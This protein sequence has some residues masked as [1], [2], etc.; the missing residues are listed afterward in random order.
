M[1][2]VYNLQL[3]T[4]NLS[5]A[6]Y[7]QVCQTNVNL[8]QD[9]N[10]NFNSEEE[11]ICPQQFGKGYER[12]IQ[13]CKINL[14]I[15]NQEFYQDISIKYPA[16]KSEDE[17]EFG[18]HLSGSWAGKNTGESFLEW[19]VAGEDMRE[20]IIEITAEKPL[21]KVDIHLSPDLL[22]SL[23]TNNNYLPLELQELLS[24]TRQEHY[25]EIAS[26]T[27]E[28]WLPLQQILHC[29]FDGC[30]KK[31]YLEGKCL[32][33]I[34]LK[35][36]QLAR[37]ELSTNLLRKLKAEDIERIYWARDIL[38]QDLNH[39]PSL[40]QLARKIG[41]NDR[42]L[43]QGF[44]QVFNTTVFGYLHNYRMMQ[45]KQLLEA[46]RLN[47]NEIARAVGY[48][49]RSAFSTAFKKQFGVSPNNYLG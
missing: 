22:K 27:P 25:N 33:L 46:R 23:V 8:Q 21:L 12:Y 18:F 15:I 2:I 24:G 30:T 10:I 43:S 29:P 37:G 5:E 44:H 9:I 28:M 31:I 4:I 34:A 41:F 48:K 1:G 35:L 6:E 14:L 38:I 20:N 3:M 36:N 19:S 47:I 49:S 40:L 45:A 11:I 39:P 16:C 26:M 13:L 32:E 17:V 7:Y 42:K